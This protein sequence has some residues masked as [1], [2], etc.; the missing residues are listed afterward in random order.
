MTR[1]RFRRLLPVVA[2]VLLLVAGVV[3][4]AERPRVVQT[5]VQV[6][7]RLTH[8]HHLGVHSRSMGAPPA[9]S[10][11]VGEWSG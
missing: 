3:W 6:H 1:D 8:Y 2:G 10:A 5:V 4:R 9:R 7:E 11:A